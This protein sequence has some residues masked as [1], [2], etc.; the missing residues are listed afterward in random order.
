MNM[1]KHI[2]KLRMAL[3]GAHSKDAVNSAEWEGIVLL[4]E[5]PELTESEYITVLEIA[6]T[7]LLRV[8]AAE[9]VGVPLDLS[10]DILSDLSSK[11]EEIIQND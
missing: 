6:R 10:D 8:N 2:E 3:Y 11:L 7:A 1:T 5:K 4:N 9:E